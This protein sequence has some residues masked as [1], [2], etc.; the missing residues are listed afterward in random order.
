MTTPRFAIVGHP[1]KGKSS[2]VATLAED[3]SVAIAPDP[4]TT[5]QARTYP[6]RRDGQT[7]YELIDTPGF[8]RAR[9]MLAWLTAHDRGAGARAEVVAAFLREHA[10]DPRFRD[11][12]ELLRPIVDGAGILYV[13]DGSRPYGGEYEPE[14]EVLRWTGRPRMALINLIGA[15]NHVDRWRTALGQF[16]SIVRVFDAVRGSFDERID[17]LRSFGAIDETWKAPLD[18]AADV[19]AEEREQRRRRAA[20]TIADLL[21][22]VLTAVE[23]TNLKQQEADPAIEAQTRERLH[24]T[25]RREEQ[26][27]RR[28]LQE[29]YHHGGLFAAE[30]AATVLTEDLFSSKSFN[31]F[32]LSST[33][34]ALTGAASGAVAGGAV[35]AMLGGASMLLGAGIGALLGGVG[36]LFGADRLAKVEVLGQPLGGFELRL[37]PITDPNFPWVMLGRALLHA[38]L[39]AERNHARREALTLDAERGAHLADDIDPAR[40]RRLEPLF[41]NLRNDLSIAA[42]DRRQLVDEIAAL[43]GPR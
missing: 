22:A 12:C 39:V 27:A 33:Q 11:E 26:L 34:L 21:C 18:R 15:G 30:P 41:R 4:G 1:N 29:I 28:S 31:V 7:L 6:M 40:R 32:G 17:L 24:A 2:I 38:Q 23:T 19:L 43:L 10:A 42:A 9:D 36:A 8:Q 5:T 3:D 37:G 35:D 14:M 16:F 13:V 25:V 20:G